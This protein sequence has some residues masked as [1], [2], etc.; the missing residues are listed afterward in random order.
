MC[1]SDLASRMI[2]GKKPRLGR[3]IAVHIVV[4]IQMILGQVGENPHFHGQSG[5]PLL[6][7]RVGGDLHDHILHAVGDHAA[8]DLVQTETI[9]RGHG[10]GQGRAGPGNMHRAD[11]TGGKSIGR[12]QMMQQMRGLGPFPVRQPSKPPRTGCCASI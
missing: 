9:G 8:H 1:S 4:I 10:R 3:E 5:Q 7:Q 12:E 2:P 6:S 11:E